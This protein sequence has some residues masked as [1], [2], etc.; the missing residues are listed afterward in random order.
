MKIKNYE[1][2]KK[3]F[4][5]VKRMCKLKFKERYKSKARLISRYPDH[6]KLI[7][8]LFSY[9]MH[10]KINR[11]AQYLARDEVTE[12]ENDIINVERRIKLEGVV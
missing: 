9:M 8:S 1:F 2:K 11:T 4:L 5:E 3:L 12:V 7:R 6:Y 10:K